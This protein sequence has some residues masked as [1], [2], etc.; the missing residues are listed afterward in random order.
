MTFFTVVESK[1]EHKDNGKEYRGISRNKL[2]VAAAYDEYGHVLLITENTSKAIKQ[3]YLD[4]FGPS[5]QTGFSFDSR[6]GKIP[7]CTDREA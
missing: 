6:R 5:Y 7:F 1:K 2:C 3:K 4:S